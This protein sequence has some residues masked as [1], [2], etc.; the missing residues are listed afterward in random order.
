[1]LKSEGEKRRELETLEYLIDFY[2]DELTKYRRQIGMK[3]VFK[4]IVTDTLIASL[5]SRLNKLLEKKNAI[6]RQVRGED[7]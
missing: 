5:E 4:V 6:N 7:R 2:C 1:M 3:T